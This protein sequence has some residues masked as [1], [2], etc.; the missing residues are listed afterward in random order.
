MPVNNTVLNKGNNFESLLQGALDIIHDSNHYT[1]NHHHNFHDS[2]LKSS[3]SQP[4]TSQHDSER[5]RRSHNSQK[6][7]LIKD[8]EEAEPGKTSLSPQSSVSILIPSSCPVNIGDI[9]AIPH[10]PNDS[11][12][13]IATTSDTS[14]VGTTITDTSMNSVPLGSVSDG[15]MLSNEQIRA[16]KHYQRNNRALVWSD[17]S[18]EEVMSKTNV[19]PNILHGT[20]FI[21]ELNCGI[22]Y[23]K[24]RGALVDAVRKVDK[25]VNIRIIPQTIKTSYRYVVNKDL[26][27][28]NLSS[29]LKTIGSKVFNIN[30]SMRTDR[31]FWSIGTNVELDSTICSKFKLSP[32]DMSVT[33]FRISY[34]AKEAPTQ[35]ALDKLSSAISSQWK[36]KV[37]KVSWSNNVAMVNVSKSEITNNITKAIIM[38]NTT[39]RNLSYSHRVAMSIAQRVE[40][41]EKHLVEVDTVVKKLT[42]Q[43]TDL[44][45][46]L[47]SHSNNN[48]SQEVNKLSKIV[49][50][51]SNGNKSST[52]SSKAPSSP[53]TRK[54]SNSGARKGRKHN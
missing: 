21:K 11:E 52:P 43:I 41:V 13:S 5:E 3:A 9:S 48:L 33:T 22:L 14:K 27:S 45:K 46:Q 49:Q 1:Q 26:N 7:L 16:L 24:S 34:K 19:S 39:L 47:A 31:E 23:F 6:D 44:A 28:N 12:V 42:K 32:V 40:A 54:K 10:N 53:T 15:S 35:K 20:S 36:V 29:L 51:M 30:V 50:G 8:I 17:Y 18:L 4:H 37:L 2:S 38:N 25:M